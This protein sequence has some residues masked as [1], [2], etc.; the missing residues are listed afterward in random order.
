A[1]SARIDGEAAERILRPSGRARGLAEAR[2]RKGDVRVAPRALHP[3]ARERAGARTGARAPLTG[4]DE[5][6]HV[7]RGEA[8]EGELGS[9]EH[10]PHGIRLPLDAAQ[11]DVAHE[12]GAVIVVRVAWAR[13]EVA[14]G[15]VGG[16]D[17]GAVVG[18]HE[19][20]LKPSAAQERAGGDPAPC[21][22][23]LEA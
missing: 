2:V 1:R 7:A 23:A 3:A 10:Q 13:N 4:G 15:N 11:R 14:C 21:D 8:A 12:R 17:R 19:A 16:V 5:G 22:G 9:P 18:A 20:E 6:A